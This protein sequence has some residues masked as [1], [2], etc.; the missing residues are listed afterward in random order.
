VEV[1]EVKALIDVSGY[2]EVASAQRFTTTLRYVEAAEAKNERVVLNT[3]DGR[4][5]ISPTQILAIREVGGVPEDETPKEAETA[6]VADLVGP[7]SK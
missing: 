2:G 5:A 7:F 6:G 4:I 3:P 1:S